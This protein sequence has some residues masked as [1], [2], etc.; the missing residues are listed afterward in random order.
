MPKPPFRPQAAGTIAFFFS[1]VA[2]ALVSV[3][4]LRRMGHSQKAKKI[5]WITM[6]GAAVIATI[7]ILIPAALGR[8]VGLG[9]EVVWYFVFPEIQDRE[10]RQWEAAHPD[11]APSSGWKALGWGFAG[12][13]AFFAIVIAMGI[14]LDATGIAPQ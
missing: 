10:F 4:S 2:G 3:I 9:L 8:P 13:A 1:V 12:L 7:L 11:V 6:L 5:F 14:L